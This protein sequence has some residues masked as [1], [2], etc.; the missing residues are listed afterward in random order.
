[1]RRT[2][3][4]GLLLT[5]SL[6]TAAQTPEALLGSA[7]HQERVTGN[8]QAAIDGYKKVLAARGVSRSVAAQAQY[9]LGVCYEK[10]GN[11][12]ARKAFE[13]VVKNYGD[14]QDLATQARARL[15]AMQAG[16]ATVRTRLL[17][18]Q[19]T[20]V[21]GRASADGS[22]FTFTDWST[23][24]L[25][26]HNLATGAKHKVTNH[27]GCAT[28]KQPSGSAFSPD[29]KRIALGT[30]R[31]KDPVGQRADLVVIGVDGKDEKLLMTGNR[32]DWVDPVSWSPDGKWVA[33]TV[34]YR[35]A[36]GEED[37]I[38]LVSPD[39]G[40]IRKFR[41]KDKLWA[42]NLRYSP[43]GKWLAYSVRHRGALPQLI[44]RSAEGED[45]P[46]TVLADN[47]LMMGWTPQGQL[48]F[49]REEGG[50]RDLYLLA[51][52]GGRST[53]SPA[54][55]HSSLEREA[56]PA[57][58]TSSGAL[59]YSTYNRRT[60]AQLLPWTSETT[61]NGA[62]IASFPATVAINHL[63]GA[64]AVHFSPDS[65]RLLV[66]NPTTGVTIRDIET[67][68]E[69]VVLPQLKSWKTARWSHDGNSL[70]FFGTNAA[71][72][73]GVHRVDSTGSATLLAELP[74]LT[75][76]FT[77]SR[78]GKTI[79]HG[80]PGKTQ[81]RDL[82]TG[83]DTTLFETPRG[84]NYDLRV[85]HDGTRLAIRGGGYLVVVDLK[86][87]AARTIY[88]APQDSGISLWALDWSPDDKQ[89]YAN[90]RTTG[91]ATDQQTWIFSPEGGEPKRISNPKQL[92]GL[93]ISSDG[94]FAAVTRMT[95]RS[96]VWALENFLP[97]R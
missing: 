81:V 54:R 52:S 53:G 1:M 88:R 93:A 30:R 31:Y 21:G 50:S 75:W 58:V 41:V 8:L 67:G 36:S 18:D 20:D 97:A 87:A 72:Q 12:E 48:L 46:E 34:V 49:A 55:V 60:E 42:E 6:V 13:A 2:L 84:G 90:V 26:V 25:A 38:V 44:V 96:Q 9:H 66:V 56:M 74:P 89:L 37:A 83:R 73:T 77:P 15:A 85:S 59:I 82:A 78:D 3:G 71:D 43:D 29:S 28:G 14:Q 11:R 40:Q 92:P 69:R 64:G 47:A 4:L 39:S 95:E 79:F 23:C 86:T 32:V 35:D 68:A 5:V 70:L 45:T 24:D 94:K 17:V 27:G 76:S 33:A 63:L 10:L 61:A 19:A 51:M 62:P 22:L 16:A 7:L 65:K 91:M 80:T 57:V